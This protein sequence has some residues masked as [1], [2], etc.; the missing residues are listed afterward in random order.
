MRLL[1]E[2]F[3]G[4]RGARTPP[5]P[6]DL[7]D[8]GAGPEI[9]KVRVIFCAFSDRG[10]RGG[11]KVDAKTFFPRFCAVLHDAGVSTFF[12]STAQELADCLTSD[13]CLVH[14]YREIDSHHIE[15]HVNTAQQIANISHRGVT[16]NAAELGARIARKDVTNQ[17]LTKAGIV[18]PRMLESDEAG[19]EVFCNDLDSSGAEV[20]RTF[21]PNRY[22]TEFIDS[23][24]SYEGVDYYTT[25]RMLCVGGVLIHCNVGA[26]PASET[27]SVHGRDAPLNPA[28]LE[29]LQEKLVYKHLE[30]LRAL[31]RRLGDVLGPGFYGHDLVI[32]AD[33]GVVHVCEVGFKFDARAYRTHLAPVAD[34]VPS[35]SDLFDGTYETLSA[36]AFLAEHT[37]LSALIRT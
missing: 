11:G 10:F 7:P 24:V 27:A 4:R 5:Q 36:R 3:L 23:H 8:I 37:A 26:R 2:R 6:A 13:A 30:D 20:S 25:V 35:H 32:C 29:F 31:A 12:A 28:L 18:V 21:D 9:E 16:F 33:T 17:Y 34:R 22:N 1:I 15:Q 19:V 14:I